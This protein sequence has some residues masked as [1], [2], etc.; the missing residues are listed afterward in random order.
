[1]ST[2]IERGPFAQL[3]SAILNFRLSSQSKKY[4]A[5]VLLLGVSNLALYYTVKY[6]MA[7]NDP[8]R[9]SYLKRKEELQRKQ[10][11]ASGQSAQSATAILAL[12]ERLRA[13]KLTEH[14]EV[15]ASEIV[16]S[17]DEGITGFAQVGGLEHIVQSLKE[18]V[19]Y[20][21]VHPHL[22]TSGKNGLLAAPKGVLLYGPPGCGKTMLAKALAKES[23]A[24][25]INL[26]V[27]TL[28]EKWFGESQKL[29]NALFSLA[30]K[31]E[32]SI[33]F[34]D[35]IDSFLRE[36]RSSDH[37]T[38]SAMKAEFLGLWDG[39][40][41]GENHRIIVIGAT[42]RPHDLDK[43]VLRRMPKKFAIKLP[44][45]DQRRQ[46]LN[47][48][49]RDTVLDGSFDVEFIVE[50]SL[51]YSGSDLKELCRNAAMIPVREYLRSRGDD[52][53]LIDSKDVTVRPL[54]TGDF[55]RGDGD[56]VNVQYAEGDAEGFEMENDLD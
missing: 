51:G 8:I 19:I 53:T 50:N 38:T 2:P 3:L 48:M 22:F 28:T 39:L 6:I 33:I 7:R 12:Q 13:L 14:E 18:S 54:R 52:V 15:I 35:E 11:A 16:S 40:G 44:N 56:D 55:F 10:L 21:L 31:L 26:H 37:E 49:L 23:G 5:D 29:V 4:L 34:I 46:I 32:P 1:M 27:S 36:R 41:A 17:S 43:A 47:L 45:S 25:F 42:N 30:K 20:P 9:R 24:T